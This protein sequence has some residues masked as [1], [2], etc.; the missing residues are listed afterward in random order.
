MLN[1]LSNIF[2]SNCEDSSS[3]HDSQRESSLRENN[4][5]R[6]KLEEIYQKNSQ[7]NDFLILKEKIENKD[8]KTVKNVH[9]TF[10]GVW[11]IQFNDLTICKIGRTN[12]NDFGDSGMFEEPV[13]SFYIKSESFNTTDFSE[14]TPLISSPLSKRKSDK[15][16]MLI[17]KNEYKT[18]EDK[19][20]EF[21]RE[22]IDPFYKF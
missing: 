19:V 1:F 15:T 4:L 14:L 10:G 22:H 17:S 21:Y 2:T 12:I 9:L 11:L 6:T 3:I 18:I 13:S 16:I 5:I 20:V 7:S 8:F